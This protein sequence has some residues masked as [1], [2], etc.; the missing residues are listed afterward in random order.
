MD[1]EYATAGIK[2]PKVCVTTSRGPSARLKQF[3][4][5]IKLIIPNSQ[6]INRGNTKV[7]EVC[8]PCVC[9]PSIRL[10]GSDLPCSRIYRYCH[11]W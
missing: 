9:H 4:K 2:D 11:C 6:R 5:E 3:V 7:D 1:D 10:V 8:S